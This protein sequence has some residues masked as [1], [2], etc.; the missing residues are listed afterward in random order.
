MAKADDLIERMRASGMRK[1]VAQG[2][3]EA[4]EKGT[5]GRKP[6]KRVQSAVD[7]LR[8]LANQLEDR[9]SGG[10]AKRKAAAKKA[11]ATRKRNAAKRSASARKGARTRAAKA[12]R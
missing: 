11:V 3:G 8:T 2:L 1:K 10:P 5:R 9:A 7:E 12:A 6:P 4:V